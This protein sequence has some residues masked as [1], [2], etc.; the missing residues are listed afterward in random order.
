MNQVRIW[1]NPFGEDVPAGLLRS[2]LRLSLGGGMQC[3]LSLTP[4]EPTAAREGERE[5]PLTDGV[6]DLR[7]GTRLPPAEIDM[8]LRAAGEAIAATAPVVVFG[9][10]AAL[11]D[12]ATLAGLEW[13]RAAIVLV[14]REP[15]TAADLLDRVR[16]ELRWAGCENPP[17]SL[18]PR[19]LAQWSSLPPYVGQGPIVH[20]GSDAADGTDLVVEAWSNH[21]ATTGHALRLVVGQADPAVV[22]AW[23]ER[24]AA[25]GGPFE[26]LASTFEPVHARDAAAIVL[27]WREVRDCRVLV[28][29][30]ASGR[31]VCVSRWSAIA[32]M[33]GRHGVCLPIGGV[34]TPSE[35]AAGGRFEP[36]ARAVAAALHAAIG[37]AG[38]GRRARQHVQEELVAGR[39]STPPRPLANRQDGRTTV[40]LEAPFFE[41][42]SSAE[43]SIETARALLRRGNVDLRLVPTVPF[44][45]DLASLRRRAPELVPLLARNPGPVDLWLASGW[46]VRTTRPE[47]RHFA[48]RVD[49]EYGALP[50]ELT[51]HVTQEADSIVVHSEHVFRTVT[52]AGRAISQVHTIAHGVDPQM[53]EQA[54][55]DREIMAWKGNLP[56]VLFCG[57]L[58]WRKG[59]DVFVRTMLAACSAGAKFC[60]VVKTVGR[61]Q[62]YSRFHLGELVQR[63]QNTPG[64]PPMLLLDRDLSREELASLYTAC[65]VMVHPYRGEGFCLPVLEARAC[66]L[67]V[68]A[69]AGGATE[70]LLAGPGAIKIPST[71]RALE[72][73]TPHVSL[74]WILE[75][76]ADEAARLLVE[77]LADLPARRAAAQKFAGSVR[78]A[79]TWDAAAEA[80]EQLAVAGPMTQCVVAPRSTGEPLV[81]LPAAPMRSVP[82]AGVPAMGV[83]ARR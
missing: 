35:S 1:G 64:T 26:I 70:Q 79:F 15:S 37:D 51:P 25:C 47:C 48:L 16:A 33:V 20:V 11:A 73:P 46:P 44:R 57:G 69:T 2:F 28:Q 71:R 82:L 62:H 3:A 53:H 65:D 17:F 66:G 72:L 74:P 10:A 6:R 4:V 8:L 83:P 21:F 63:F 14:A 58:V 52:A 41:T 32:P 36:N 30:L 24:L 78:S 81:T 45:M 77:T 49:W 29:A 42:S 56:A 13:P 18:E 23:R 75:P 67:P 9:P 5:I 38:T 59:F 40:V 39:P 43:L 34:F 22:D 60:V 50:I 12:L 68:L 7:I 76:A 31:P 19:F 54:V 61:D 55:P 80:I 27:P